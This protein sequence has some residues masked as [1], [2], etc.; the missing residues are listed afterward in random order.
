[1]EA[2]SLTHSLSATYCIVE[3]I[4]A[5]CIGAAIAILILSLSL[6]Y[7][8]AR[9]RSVKLD[10]PQTG[11]V[12]QDLK[13]GTTRSALIAHRGRMNVPHCLSSPWLWWRTEG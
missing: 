10:T 5:C 2:T 8:W 1:M 9:Y 12:N 6:C 4:L 3:I 7:S 11:A 13:E